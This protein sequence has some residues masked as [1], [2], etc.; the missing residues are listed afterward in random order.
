MPRSPVE[1][2][3]QA[4]LSPKLLESNAARRNKHPFVFDI[5]KTIKESMLDI[6]STHN[7]SQAREVTAAGLK[8]W[9]YSAQCQTPRKIICGLN[10]IPSELYRL[11]S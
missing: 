3:I 8:E 6:R 4:R 9:G 11:T 7:H 5:G 10:T 1:V 2:C